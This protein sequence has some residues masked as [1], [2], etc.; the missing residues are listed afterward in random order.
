M[1][2]TTPSSLSSRT[3]GL[4]ECWSAATAGSR[5]KTVQAHTQHNRKE[6]ATN[7]DRLR[8]KGCLLSRN[9]SLIAHLLLVFSQGA[10]NSANVRAVAWLQYSSALASA[11]SPLPL[12]LDPASSARDRFSP[13]SSEP[14]RNPSFPAM[15]VIPSPHHPFCRGG[16]QFR[17][18]RGVPR[19]CWDRRQAQREIPSPRRRGFPQRVLAGRAAGVTGR[20]Q[21]TNRQPPRSKM[22][23]Q[24]QFP[25]EELLHRARS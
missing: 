2:S 6:A 20:C 3:R 22:A 12:A 8:Q 13:T 15:L 5:W 21:P 25:R 24:I 10:W 9:Q 16:G 7:S 14:R 4:E 17:R 23:R 19:D 1:G 11:P 18:A